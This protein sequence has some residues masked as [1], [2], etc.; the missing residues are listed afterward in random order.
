MQPVQQVPQAARPQEKR[1]IG[2][3]VA[4]IVHRI[5]FALWAI[6]IAAAV[7]LVGYLIWS[8][9]GKKRT[10][11]STLLVENAQVLFNTWGSEQDAA[12]K[13]ALEKDLSDQLDGLIARYP[14]KYGGQRGLFLRAELRFKNK[15][16]DDARK[17]YEE[18]VRRFP[19]SYLSAISLFNAGVSAEEKGDAEAALG[20]Y[21]RVVEKYPD[22]GASPRALFDAARLDE[23]KGAWEDA[24]K[25]YER[26]DSDYA[27]ST[28][29]KLGKNRIIALKV[30]GKLK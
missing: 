1:K 19:A 21:M 10:I 28:W 12:K 29:T 23:Q 14:R 15:A 8:E 2:D 13:S 17:D 27:L 20:L 18:L 16:W 22:S 9:V 6:L 4:H 26:L 3:V 7:F 30:E 11:D 25:K 24:R 5:R